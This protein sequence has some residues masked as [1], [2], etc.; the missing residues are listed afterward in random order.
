ML[1]PRA[2]Y[3]NQFG[4]NKKGGAL[5]WKQIIGAPYSICYVVTKEAR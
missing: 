2:V 3:Q 1:L 5:A 4:G